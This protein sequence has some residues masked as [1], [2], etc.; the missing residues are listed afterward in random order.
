MP[1]AVVAATGATAYAQSRA[2]A[3]ANLA[4]IDI[5]MRLAPAGVRYGAGAKRNQVTRWLVELVG[6]PR[7]D[8][9]VGTAG[10]LCVA[11]CHR[12]V[13]QVGV[14]R[15]LR[16][17]E[18]VSLLS[19]T[20][21]QRMSAPDMDRGTPPQVREGEVYPSIATERRPQQRE[22]RLVLVDWQQLP[23]AESLALGREA[24]GHEPDL[25][26]KRFRH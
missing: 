26:Q 8:V 1:C 24:E 12:G 10:E 4:D 13:E 9:R 18:R 19:P 25:R 3:P 5:E 6:G 16:D 22:E 7:Q 2:A 14:R 20:L 15:Q 21:A 17:G 11:I 23:V